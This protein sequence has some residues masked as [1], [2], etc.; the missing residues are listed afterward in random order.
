MNSEYVIFISICIRE[1]S[2]AS[3]RS[4][5]SGLHKCNEFF[6]QAIMLFFVYYFSPTSSICFMICLFAVLIEKFMKHFLCLCL[7]FDISVSARLLRTDG[8]PRQHLEVVK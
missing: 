4:G 5:V 6:T 7:V 2:C 3:A 1:N 8:C